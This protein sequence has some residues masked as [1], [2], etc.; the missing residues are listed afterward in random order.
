MK[1]QYLTQDESGIA[2]LLIYD[3]VCTFALGL[4][5]LAQMS[6]CLDN[7][8]QDNNATDKVNQRENLG[9]LSSKD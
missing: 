6:L 7:N 9:L 8:S 4:C 3:I 1:C 5:S 2:A